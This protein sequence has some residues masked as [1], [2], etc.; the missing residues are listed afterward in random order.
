MSDHEQVFIDICDELGCA[1]DN[2]AALVAI[3]ALKERNVAI[4]DIAAER[5]RQIEQEGWT[6]IHDDQHSTGEMARAA[7]SY[8]LSA[9]PENINDLAVIN[10]LWPWEWRWF[11]PR[12]KREDL[13]R[14]GALV[15][16]E[17]ERLDRQP[18]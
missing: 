9:G 2:E 8:A 10:K 5:R 17:I 3:A 11:K 4:N 18:R 15:V 7:A 6:S 13:V 12:S 14:A 1:R 16:A